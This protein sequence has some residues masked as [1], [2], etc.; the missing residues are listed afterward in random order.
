MTFV[1]TGFVR[2][3]ETQAD[4]MNPYG[5]VNAFSLYTF[6]MCVT[7]LY[8]MFVLLTFCTVLVNGKTLHL[9][10]LP[11]VLQYVHSETGEQAF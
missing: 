10:G 4:L 9:N 1:K 8:H 11:V 3:F 7:L 2:V 6:L 5:C